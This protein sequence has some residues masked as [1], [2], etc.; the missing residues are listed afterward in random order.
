MTYNP[1]KINERY[2]SCFGDR[3]IGDSMG[4]ALKRPERLTLPLEGWQHGETNDRVDCDAHNVF[5]YDNGVLNSAR[6]V[7]GRWS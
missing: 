7:R 4:E 5:H 1:L 3:A 6:D 2:F